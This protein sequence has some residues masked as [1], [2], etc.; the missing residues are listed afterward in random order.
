MNITELKDILQ[1]V[2]S[3]V[4]SNPNKAQKYKKIRIFRANDKEGYFCESFT[5]TQSFHK[6]LNYSDFVSFVDENCASAFKNTVLTTSTET[7]TVLSNKKGNI[8]I[9]KNPL[10]TGQKSPKSSQNKQK[11]Y[12]LEEGI[13]VPFLIHLGVMTEQGKVIASKYDKFRQINRFLEFINDILPLYEDSDKVYKV[14]DFGCGKSYLT[15]ALY[16]FLVQI[17]HKK[18]QIIGVDLKEEVIKNCSNLAK[19]WGY[20]GLEFK[21][22]RIE[23]FESKDAKNNLDLVITLHACDT[24]TDYALNYAVKN[25]ATAI[26]SV[27]CCQHEIN[28]KL[29]KD[30]PNKGLNAL[31]KYGIVKERFAA[32]VTDVMRAELLEAQGYT[33]QLMEFIDIE[34]TAKNLLI[35]AVKKPNGAKAKKSDSYE[36]LCESLGVENTLAGLLN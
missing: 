30:L 13:P 7:V 24:A 10:K 1:D 31:M 32:L 4:F 29:S 33:V 15:F 8:T 12:I 27:P 34:H 17:R 2:I 6:T 16:H 11:H 21:I 19:T 18:A 28:S 36:S 23:D 5:N 25:N 20:E 26:L 35:R 22:G 3:A 9:L 14:L